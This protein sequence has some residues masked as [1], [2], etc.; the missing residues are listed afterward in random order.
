MSE[1]SVQG[2]SVAF[3]RM[4]YTE[5]FMF[6]SSAFD[7]TERLETGLGRV[8]SSFGEHDEAKKF[9]ISFYPVWN[10]QDS[11]YV[12]AYM[13]CTYR[14]GKVNI[15]KLDLVYFNGAVNGEVHSE[16]LLEPTLVDI[17][18]RT[19]LRNRLALLTNPNQTT[20]NQTR[21]IKR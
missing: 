13:D 5:L 10:Q 15:D 17:P 12:T 14:Q 9:S 7:F 6:Y 2:L 16:C 3:Q 19:T 21:R 20:V 11:P 8:G 1:F 4:G 18:D